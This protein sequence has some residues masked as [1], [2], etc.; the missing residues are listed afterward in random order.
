MVKTKEP[1]ANKWKARRWSRRA[2]P[3]GGEVLGSQE[4]LL[5]EMASAAPPDTDVKQLMAIWRVGGRTSSAMNH[6]IPSPVSCYYI[7]QTANQAFLSQ[8]CLSQHCTLILYTILHCGT[9]PYPMTRGGIGMA[10]SGGHNGAAKLQPNGTNAPHRHE[11][12]APRYCLLRSQPNPVGATA[13]Y[14]CH[15]D[16]TRMGLCTVAYRRVLVDVHTCTHV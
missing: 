2:R 4:Q 3:A 12:P 9:T 1:I 8:Y 13:K 11:H 10:P 7:K 16:P 14:V 6:A 5:E 15:C